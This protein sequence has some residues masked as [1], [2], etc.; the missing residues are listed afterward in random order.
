MPTLFVPHGG[1]PMP[2]MGDKNHEQ[3]T[4][5]LKQAGADLPRRPTAILVI[6]AHWE[7]PTAAVLTAAIPPLLF[8]YYN[9][10]PETYKY[11]YPAPGAPSLA[12]DVA[13][14]LQEAGIPCREDPKRGFDHGTFVP[15]LLMYPKAD[16]P[17][18]QLS[19]VK[20]LDPALHLK[21]G[22]A[23]RDLRQQGVL[24]LGS[25]MSYHNMAGFGNPAAGHKPSVLFDDYLVKA[26][27][28]EQREELLT[29]WESAPAARD[30]HVREEHLLPLMVVAG[31]APNEVGEQI[32]SD[33]LFGT[34][35]SGFQFG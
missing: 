35:V 1:G 23:L 8:D 21:M 27:T 4:A 30:C 18:T 16:I 12:Q 33:L 14:K 24:L 26:C 32:F 29:A 10:P 20:G 17:V 22:L 13:K 31:A 7:E 28:G 9:F 25:G 3:L 19:L 6:S 2:L 34:K 11:K 5:W 15:L